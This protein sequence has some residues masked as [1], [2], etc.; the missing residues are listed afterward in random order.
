MDTVLYDA[1]KRNKLNVKKVAEIGVLSF[2]ESAI[3]NFCRDGLLC[4]LYEA[5]PAFCDEIREDIKHLPN[6]TLNEFAV[7]DYNGEMQMCLAGA[8]TF[9]AIQNSSPAI[10]HDGYDKQLGTILTVPCRDFSEVDAGDYDVVTIDIEGGEWK[11]LSR[12]K[13]RP[14]AIAI[15]TQS[16]DYINPYLGSIT[17]WM[18]ENGYKVWIWNDTD[19]IFFK[20]QP[21]SMG[22][23]NYI[24]CKWHNF[25][26]FSG[27][28]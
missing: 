22:V 17:D 2:K 9:N 15:E 27:R 21:P 26:Y 23:K 7:S 8:S 11:V 5:I 4:D 16:R 13:S 25:R 18:L 19:T 28:L 24:L 14:I 20:G 3:Q 1:V 6:V 10:N 12:M